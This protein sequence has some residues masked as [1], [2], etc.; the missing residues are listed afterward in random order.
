VTVEE[1]AR[2]KDLVVVTI[3]EMHVIDLPKVSSMRI[4]SS[5]TR[6][7]TIRSNATDESKPSRRA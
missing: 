4:R 5:S 6:A 2:G 1:A 7:T 3:P